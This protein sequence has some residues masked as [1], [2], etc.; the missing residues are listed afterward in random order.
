MSPY[1]EDYAK[2]CKMLHNYLAL[3]QKTLVAVLPVHTSDER[4]LYH[5]LVRKMV[6]NQKKPNWIDLAREWQLHANGRTIFYKV[7]R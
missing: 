6:V 7:C 5:A 2:G 4:I 3:N 1:N